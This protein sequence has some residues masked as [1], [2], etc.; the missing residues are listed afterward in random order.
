MYPWLCTNVCAFPVLQVICDLALE[1]AFPICGIYR[2]PDR[3]QSINFKLITALKA[4]DFSILSDARDFCI[5]SGACT[6]ALTISSFLA[7]SS[8]ERVAMQEGWGHP[9]ADEDTMELVNDLRLL[10]HVP[11]VQQPPENALLVFRPEGCPPAY[12]KIEVTNEEELDRVLNWKQR[13]FSCTH[14]TDSGLWLHTTNLQ[15]N[16]ACGDLLDVVSGPAVQ[17]GGEDD[18]YITT[19]VC[20]HPHPSMGKGLFQKLQ[21]EPCPRP[22]VTRQ[23]D[24]YYQPVAKMVS[25]EASCYQFDV[26]NSIHSATPPES[27]EKQIRRHGWPS[28]QQIEDII[29]LPM[30]LVLV[31]HKLSADHYYQARLSWSFCEL[32]LISALPEHIRQGYIACKYVLKRF[33]HAYRGEGEN[34]DGRSRVGSFHLKTVFLHHLQNFPPPLIKSP[35]CLIR[36]LLLDLDDHLCGGSLPHF[37]L[38][39]C[40]LLERVDVE[41][42]LVARRAINAILSDPLSAILTSPTDASQIYGYIKPDTLANA[43]CQMASN[44]VA[45]RH[46]QELVDL[47]VRLDAC[48]H[49][50]YRWQQSSD[51]CASHLVVTGRP[52]PVQLA[53]RLKEL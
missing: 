11:Q 28:L 29:Q 38:S 13:K 24:T 27:A 51:D 42:R 3:C 43:F 52:V 19:L 22:A 30:M 12:C 10:V 23:V 1:A 2:P 41:E 25:H 14:R 16:I 5:L 34:C 20:S 39:D 53:H 18:E 26:E 45:E 33:L 48:R 49:R 47:L 17:H 36:D 44:P 7:G 32:Y 8:G 40:D 15:A 6:K 9:R 46:R 21:G 35:F 37:F 4:R 31:G 50:R